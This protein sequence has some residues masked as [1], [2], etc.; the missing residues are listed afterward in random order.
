MIPIL[1][2]IY[3]LLINELSVQIESNMSTQAA[4]G[5]EDDDEDIVSISAFCN[6]V[7]LKSNLL[8]H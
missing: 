8:S 2:K 6:L 7:L 4:I 5:E 3:K 1:V